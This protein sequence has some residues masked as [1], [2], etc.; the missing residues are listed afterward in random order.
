MKRLEKMKMARVLCDQ[1]AKKHL[2]LQSH[3]AIPRAYLKGNYLIEEKIPIET[4][5]FKY[6]LGLYV[7]FYDELDDAVKEFVRLYLSS[8]FNDL[9]FHVNLGGN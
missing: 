8:N 3:L 2:L 6:Q 1:L 5:H 7:E 9:L 4:T